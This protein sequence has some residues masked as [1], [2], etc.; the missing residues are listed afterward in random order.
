M[1][2]ARIILILRDPAERAYSQYL[3][4]VSV[5]LT[6]ATFREHLTECA[7]PQRELGIFHPFLEVGLYARQVQ[8]FLDCF[9]R[10]RV[11]IYWYEEAWPMPPR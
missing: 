7:R 11:R 4:Q 10:D 2:D 9:P 8:R 1:P 5:G 6:R 3:H